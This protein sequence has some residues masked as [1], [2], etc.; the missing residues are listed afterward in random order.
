MR[1]FWIWYDN[2]KEMRKFLLTL[3]FIAIALGLISLGFA[4][5]RH[6][7][8]LVFGGFTFFLLVFLSRIRFSNKEAESRGFHIRGRRL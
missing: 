3:L 1:R 8:Y 7:P 4:T 5:E 2:L 6:N